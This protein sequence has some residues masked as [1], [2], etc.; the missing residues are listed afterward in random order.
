MHR[1]GSALQP[2]QQTCFSTWTDPVL[3]GKSSVKLSKVSKKSEIIKGRVQKIP[4]ESVSM[5]VPGGR[6][7]QRARAHTSL[8]FLYPYFEPIC[9]A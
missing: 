4:I 6:G 1:E 3:S 5:L 9:L 7:P 2:A 8:G